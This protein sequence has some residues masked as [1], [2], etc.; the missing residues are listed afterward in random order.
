MKVQHFIR[1]CIA[2]SMLWGI[3]K[4]IKDHSD[5]KQTKKNKKGFNGGKIS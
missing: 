1:G 5:L 4:T 2:V 3:C